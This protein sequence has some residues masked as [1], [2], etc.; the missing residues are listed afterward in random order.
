MWG[1]TVR[2]TG[3]PADPDRVRARIE[4]DPRFP[5]I[6]L[7]LVIDLDEDERPYLRTVTVAVDGD[8]D[9]DR[10]VTSQDLRSIPVRG[11]IR[12]VLAERRGDE[13]GLDAELRVTAEVHQ[14]AAKAGEDPLMAVARALGVSRS[15][16][17]NRVRDARVAGLLP[18]PRRR[19]LSD[20]LDAP[21]QGPNA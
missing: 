15:T 21:E 16:A 8:E 7:S 5:G 11:V 10:Q 19:R 13:R 12:D 4:N 3:D 17:A 18:W 20:V 14:L 1:V 9:G 2:F 6:R